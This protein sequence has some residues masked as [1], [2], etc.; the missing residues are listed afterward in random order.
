MLFSYIRR[1]R[2]RIAPLGR[3]LLPLAVIIRPYLHSILINTVKHYGKRFAP[4]ENLVI[5]IGISFAQVHK[6]E[7]Q[8]KSNLFGN[9]SHILQIKLLVNVGISIS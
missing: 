9:I 6:A 3:Y 2:A 1:K 8:I 4:L 7:D 5:H